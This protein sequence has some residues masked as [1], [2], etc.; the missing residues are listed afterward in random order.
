MET[1][2]CACLCASNLH[3]A[4]DEA[5]ECTRSKQLSHMSRYRGCNLLQ[6]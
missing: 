1:V 6:Q 2:V 4:D 3:A 5:V